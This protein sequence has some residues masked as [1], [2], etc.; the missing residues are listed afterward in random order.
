MDKLLPQFFYFPKS[1]Q[2]LKYHSSHTIHQHSYFNINCKIWPQKWL[3]RCLSEHQMFDVW[4]LISI[5]LSPLFQ[6]INL[7]GRCQSG[8]RSVMRRNLGWGDE[9]TGWHL[10]LP[11]TSCLVFSPL[12]RDHKFPGPGPV[13]LTPESRHSVVV[14]WV[15]HSDPGP[16]AN[17]RPVSWPMDQSEAGTVL[18]TGS[19]RPGLACRVGTSEWAGPSLEWVS[20][21]PDTTRRGSHQPSH[22]TT[23]NIDHINTCRQH[24]SRQCKQWA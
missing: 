11:H 24:T 2:L 22:I 9:D 4:L 15:E 12:A 5:T 8:L 16:P 14:V 10:S 19:V 13:R 1:L 6:T 21:K 17:Q 18:P 23:R 20:T 7:S 3:T